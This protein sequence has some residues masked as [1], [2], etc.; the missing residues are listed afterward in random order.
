[1]KRG[2]A[3][4]KVLNQLVEALSWQAVESSRGELA[5]AANFLIDLL[6]LLAHGLPH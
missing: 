1:V 2:S 4:L 6:T 3:P 5:S